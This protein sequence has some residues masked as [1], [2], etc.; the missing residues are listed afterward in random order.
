MHARRLSLPRLLIVALV[1]TLAIPATAFPTSRLELPPPS[2][3]QTIGTATLHLVDRS[4]VDQPAGTEVPREL[5]VQLWYP[6]A[7]SGGRPASYMSP[8]LAGAIET[9]MGLPAGT[10]G[11]LPTHA[12]DAV[13]V[14][15][16][17]HP[18]LLFSHGL[19][20]MREIHAALLEELASRGYVVAAIS[21]TYDAGLVEFPD[22]RLVSGVAPAAP[23]ASERRLLLTTRVADFRFVLDQLTL[24]ATAPTG[25]LSG[26]LDL[27][28]VGTLGHSFGGATAASAMLAD[29]RIRAG[30]DLDGRIWGKVVRKGLDRPFMLLIGDA[31]GGTPTADQARFFARL[32]AERYALH[33]AGAGHFSFT[34]LGSFAPALPGLDELFDI[35]SIDPARADRAIRAYVRAFFDTA[36]LGRRD[37]LLAGPSSAYPEVRFL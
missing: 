25:L 37:P 1:A 18:L 22:G 9:T 24:L 34:D 19:G 3:T 15:A 13:P 29:S 20:T 16:G 36:L 21:H 30:V 6:A 12:A 33:L 23:S 32:R 5:M 26:R 11:S 27:R 4:R 2:G 17:R 7:P 8:G 10:F 31:L 28:K 35:G 14:A